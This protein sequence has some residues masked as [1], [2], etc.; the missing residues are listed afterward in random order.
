MQ[1]NMEI[2]KKKYDYIKMMLFI[3]YFLF[4]ITYAI[5]D[6]KYP[7]IIKNPLPVIDSWLHD[8]P[9]LLS[10]SSFLFSSTVIFYTLYYSC[11]KKIDNFLKFLALFFLI[12]NPFTI[13]YILIPGDN[14][15]YAASVFFSLKIYFNLLNKKYDS[16]FIFFLLLSGISLISP[17][18][19]IIITQIVLLDYFYNF[20]SGNDSK[21]PLTHITPIILI[22]Y[23]LIFNFSFKNVDTL[24]D[25]ISSI[26]FSIIHMSNSIW[27]AFTLISIIGFAL[28]LTTLI[29]N[30]NK[31][32][33]F[34][35]YIILIPISCLSFSFDSFNFPFF[36]LLLTFSF[37]Q[38]KNI[39][40][41]YSYF[42]QV[43]LIILSFS[44]F[45]S[46]INNYK[47]QMLFSENV[48]SHLSHKLDNNNTYYI[49]NSMS[50]SP[51]LK[52]TAL[53]PKQYWNRFYESDYVWDNIANEKNIF[54]IHKDQNFMLNNMGFD[55]YK[56]PT[57]DNK[58]Y[59]IMNK[60]EF[61]YIFFKKN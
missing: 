45:F 23:I 36:I 15:I 20:F 3:T 61:F 5:I 51:A 9:L 46:V 21:K 6:V 8:Y 24:S 1:S 27:L 49:I 16:L 57:I 32:L 58:Y 42:L 40:K 11:V 54:F 14:I 48:L 25:N 31:F 52:Y 19:I 50:Y 59:S 29:K 17:Y 39:S 60:N 35:C 56:E 38:I 7:I 37:S 4:N 53:Y 2:N 47:I 18:S 22:I 44:S 55:F 43:A 10:L 12:I 28:W 13:K 30:T 33:N 41:K 26:Y 34:F